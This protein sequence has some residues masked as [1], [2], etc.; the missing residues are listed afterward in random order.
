M[1]NYW[2]GSDADF[3]INIGDKVVILGQEGTE[4]VL[5]QGRET[6]PA[7]W[8][9]IKVPA[10]SPFESVKSLQQAARRWHGDF[11][12]VMSWHCWIYVGNIVVNP[13]SLTHHAATQKDQGKDCRRLI[14]TFQ[15]RDDHRH[16]KTGDNR[17]SDGSPVERPGISK[18]I[19][20]TKILLTI[21]DKQ[22]QK[23]ISQFCRLHIENQN[24][25]SAGRRARL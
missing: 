13:T 16:S 11:S 19:F 1:R 20:L 14:S 12:K 10:R 25:F 7:L 21:I 5:P 6:I 18:I 2:G 22:E 17:K 8:W 15:L 3:S 9:P 23:A 24:N 4:I